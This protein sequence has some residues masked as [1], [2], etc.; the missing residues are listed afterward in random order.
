MAIA[1]FV[2]PTYDFEGQATSFILE[3]L[4]DQEFTKNLNY[5]QSPAYFF[6]SLGHLKKK[7]NS[8]NFYKNKDLERKLKKTLKIQEEKRAQNLSNKL[9]KLFIDK[10]IN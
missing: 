7:K 5:K 10:K 2:E 9:N 1:D 6:L 4:K 8:K 3:S